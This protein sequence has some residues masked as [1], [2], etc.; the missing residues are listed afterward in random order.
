MTQARSFPPVENPQ[1]TVLILGSM[2]G[3]ASL[4]AGQYYAHPRNAFWPIMGDLIGAYPSLPYETRIQILRSSGIALWDV[5][6]SCARKG[7]LDANIIETTIAPNDFNTFF[8]TH[9][10]VRHVFFNGSMAEKSYL[11]YVQP[12][13]ETK[14]FRFQRLPSTSPAHAAKSYQQKLAA[15][16]A[17]S[18]PPELALLTG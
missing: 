4:L 7:S 18:Y 3:K 15:W 14:L 10:N 1:A 9:T 12:L 16:R 5:L 11:R 6:E 2:P 8:L 13:L 17:V